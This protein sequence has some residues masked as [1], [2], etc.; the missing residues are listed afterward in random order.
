M[1]LCIYTNAWGHDKCSSPFQDE[2]GTTLLFDLMSQAEK[3]QHF[4]RQA[5]YGCIVTAEGPYDAL[6]RDAELSNS[7]AM[8]IDLSSSVV[9]ARQVLDGFVET[10]RKTQLRTRIQLAAIEKQFHKVI[11]PWL[12]LFCKILVILGQ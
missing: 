11:N 3:T 1:W 12:A 10:Q 2:L 6:H 5:R 4:I 9:N 8:D 7:S